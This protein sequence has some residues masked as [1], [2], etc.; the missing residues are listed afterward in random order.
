MHA[1][2]NLCLDFC[3]QSPYVLCVVEFIGTQSSSALC[4]TPSI[5]SSDL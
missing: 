4:A 5:F 3:A 2:K 1:V